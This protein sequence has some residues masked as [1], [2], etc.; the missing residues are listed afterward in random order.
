M[1]PKLDNP[2]AKMTPEPAKSGFD[3][4]HAAPPQEPP[5]GPWAVF[6]GAPGGMGVPRRSRLRM[7]TLV[8]QRWMAIGGQTLAMTVCGLIFK[9]DL[10]YAACFALIGLSTWLNLILTF[11]SP[12]QRLALD[13]ERRCS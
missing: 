1:P 7:R 12:G 4:P 13:W 10:P 8:T 5:R 2:A 6:A 3:R 9:F 11:S